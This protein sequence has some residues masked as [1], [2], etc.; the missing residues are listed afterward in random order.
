MGHFSTE[1]ESRSSPRHRSNTMLVVITSNILQASQGEGR[2]AFCGASSSGCTTPSLS[3]ST[4][5]S[6]SVTFP[7][8][9]GLGIGIAFSSR[10]GTSSSLSS[11]SCQQL[12]VRTPD[13]QHST[14]ANLFNRKTKHFLVAFSRKHFFRNGNNPLE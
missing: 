3:N 2:I 4:S 1:S 6:S 14:N 10:S 8:S 11:S 12:L 5:D 7:P 9:N 13:N